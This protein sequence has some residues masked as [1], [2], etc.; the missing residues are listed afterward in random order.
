M[1]PDRRTESHL[2][3]SRST[4]LLRGLA[5]VS[6]SSVAAQTAHSQLTDEFLHL[7]DTAMLTDCQDDDGRVMKLSRKQSANPSR[8]DR[9]ACVQS[10]RTQANSL[11]QR[12]EPESLLLVVL[13]ESAPEAR[14]L[15]IFRE[16]AMH[17]T[18]HST[19]SGP[20]RLHRIDVS[21]KFES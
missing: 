9:K 10:I 19:D 4:N 12:R 7:L 20:L 5:F 6:H 15:S 11:K 8:S 17:F 21:R 2:F 1:L 14:V 13:R 3:P 16:Q 18:T